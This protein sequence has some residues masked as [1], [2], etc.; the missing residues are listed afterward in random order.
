[1]SAVLVRIT[2][3]QETSGCDTNTLSTLA[4]EE[5]KQLVLT[6][7]GIPVVFPQRIPALPQRVAVHGGLVHHGNNILAP[8]GGE[9][10]RTELFTSPVSGLEFQVPDMTMIIRQQAPPPRC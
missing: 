9:D 1:M 3:A 4:Q 7:E 10:G 8:L 2:A 6:R 5:D